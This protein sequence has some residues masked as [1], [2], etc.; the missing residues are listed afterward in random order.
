[1]L[2]R[3]PAAMDFGVNLVVPAELRD[4]GMGVIKEAF[5][6][7]LK[8]EKDEQKR[9]GRKGVRHAQPDRQGRA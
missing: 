6:Q 3:F 7:G 8:N 2:R 4:V 1:M 5:E 9:A